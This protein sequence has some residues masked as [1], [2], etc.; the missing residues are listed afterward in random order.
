MVQ[1]TKLPVDTSVNATQLA[2][3]MFG[4][5]VEL[6]SATYSGDPESKGIYTSGEAVSPGVVPSDSGIILSS[7]RASDFTHD[8]GSGDANQGGGFGSDAAGGVDGNPELNAAAGL[9]TFDGAILEATFI[10]DGPVLT[11]QLVFSS[12]EYPEYA[13]T[14]FNERVSGLLCM[15]DPV[16]AS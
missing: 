13:N 9:P 8:T 10:P 14:N 4:E 11:M 16:H 2:E 7:G 15:T 5:G 1:A 12:D 3:N 6:V